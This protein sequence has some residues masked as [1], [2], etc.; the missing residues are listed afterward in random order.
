MLNSQ[1]NKI[2]KA[3]VAGAIYLG[4]RLLFLPSL[5]LATTLRHRNF[6]TIFARWDAQWYQSIASHGY[7]YEVVE[8]GRTLSNEAFFPLFPFAERLIH[9]LFTTSYLDSGIIVSW[10]CGLWAAIVIYEVVTRLANPQI[11]LITVFLW[12]VYPIAYVD[13]LAYSETLFTALVATALFMLQLK[14]TWSAAIFA[15][16]A[17]LTRPTGLAVGLAVSCAIAIELWR[18]R[19]ARRDWSRYLALTL[20]VVGWLGF[21]LYL[22]KKNHSLTS[23]FQVQ[24]HWGNG[25]DGGV[26]FLK[27]ISH[28]L[29]SAHFIVGLLLILLC[30]ALIYLL[31]QVYR[32]V[33]Y[34][35]VLIFTTLLVVLS[36]CTQ[37]YFGSKPRY[38]LPA[39]PLLIP[40]A[41]ALSE[42]GKSIRW[43]YYGVLVLLGMTYGAIAATGHGPP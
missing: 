2:H 16:L 23:Y 5:W 14:R 36:F 28:Y 30:A 26:H 15:A 20:P 22:A 40:I 24:S 21:V 32:R 43:I 12:S 34:L 37:G 3:F 29:F 7:G 1:L 9:T 31:V 8:K 27:W 18:N 4:L 17:G 38:L 6:H 41:Y 25:F 11:G 42:R 10:L 35:P 39:F 33:H 19:D 13:N